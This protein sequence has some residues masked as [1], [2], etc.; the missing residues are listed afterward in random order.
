M[1]EPAIRPG[2]QPVRGV[3]QQGKPAFEDRAFDDL[4][5][6]AKTGGTGQAKVGGKESPAPT[7]PLAALGG[8]GQVENAALRNVLAQ[9]QGAGTDL[10]KTD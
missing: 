3:E 8:F 4:L 9:A 6:E 5:N 2:N 10:T 1:L 7:N